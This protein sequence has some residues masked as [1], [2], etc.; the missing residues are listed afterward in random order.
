MNTRTCTSLT[1]MAML[2]TAATAVLIAG[3]AVSAEITRPMPISA[4]LEGSA[5]IPALDPAAQTPPSA[6]TPQ[7]TATVTPVVAERSA[8][9][10]TPGVELF[11]EDPGAEDVPFDSRLISNLTQHSF[12]TDGLD[13][14]P[15]LSEAVGL[16]AFASTRVSQHPDIFVKKIDGYTVTQ[17]TNDPA[18]DIQPRFSPDGRQV[19]FS[20]N[21]AGTWDVWI[22]N[23][24]GTGLTPLTSDGADEMSPCWSPDGSQ[25]AYAVWGHRSGR[26][27]IWTQSVFQPGTRRFLAYG[28]FP[29]WAPDGGRIVFQRSRDR[30][31]RLFSIWSVELENGEARRPTEIA[32]NDSAACIAPRWA[33]DGHMVVF[34]EVRER[35]RA[36]TRDSSTPPEASIWAVEAESGVRT[37][38]TDGAGPDFN[39][40][41]ATNGR[42][43]F[44]SA[45]AG[46]ENIWSLQ[47]TVSPY[48]TASNTETRVS[49]AEK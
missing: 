3:C 38:L 32:R 43:Y 35:R 16:L 10:Q 44:V 17:L 13:F 7:A 41:W 42:V 5:G 20:S 24:D 22:I 33:P 14:D 23:L 26:W 49:N 28:M 1:R 6:A 18:D 31:D 48:H 37:K 34:C 36:E 29:D 4:R 15:D 40:V 2:A 30:G 39:P 27:E 21:R 11:G 9:V 12:T 45:R 19:V 46:T 25:I 47:T 8:L